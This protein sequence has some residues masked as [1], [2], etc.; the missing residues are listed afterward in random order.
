MQIQNQ[1]IHYLL[2]GGDW[3]E[4]VL[5]CDRLSL[6]ELSTKTIV[7][8]ELFQHEHCTVP[9]V[10]RLTQ[11]LQQQHTVLDLL[12]ASVELFWDG[13]GTLLWLQQFSVQK[14]PKVL[15]QRLDGFLVWCFL[16]SLQIMKSVH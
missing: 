1:T 6:D 3:L 4:L 15:I 2:W 5:G 13:M 12:H 8:G 11:V 7:E 10:V 16:V 9:Q 14:L